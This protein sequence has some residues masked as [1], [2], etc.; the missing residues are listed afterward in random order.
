MFLDDA[1]EYPGA[2]GAEVIICGIRR[3]EKKKTLSD[4]QLVSI[5]IHFGDRT[6]RPP[7]SAST[8]STD[9]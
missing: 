9:R 5:E 2:S 7:P 8:Y 3:E 1:T 6:T 4:R